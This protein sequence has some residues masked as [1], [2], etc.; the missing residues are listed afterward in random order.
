MVGGVVFILFL[1]DYLGSR[2][3]IEIVVKIQVRQGYSWGLEVLVREG[4][5]RGDS[6]YGVGLYF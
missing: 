6:L 3:E 5:G 4:I 1:K 2:M